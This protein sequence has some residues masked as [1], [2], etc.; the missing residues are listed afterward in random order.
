MK[1]RGKCTKGGETWKPVRVELI[2]YNAMYA[3]TRERICEISARFPQAVVGL[4][5]VRVPRGEYDL[6]YARRKT[7][8]HAVYDFTFPGKR[9]V[10]GGNPAGVALMLPVRDAD[11]VV[12]ITWPEQGF[13]GEGGCDTGQ[14]C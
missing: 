12:Q 4:Q 5:S 14:V 10:R 13:A 9:G 1:R 11:F 2:S 8:H 3:H 7:A 6:P